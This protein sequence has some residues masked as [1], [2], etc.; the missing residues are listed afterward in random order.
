MKRKTF[1]IFFITCNICIAVL[2]IK[3]HTAIV[4]QLYQKQ[5]NEKTKEALIQKRDGVLRNLYTL[6]NPSS[7]KQF[8]T[9]QLNMHKVCL[10]QIKTVTSN[11]K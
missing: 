7:I 1:V 6:K 8:A 10:H 3:N 5:R 9:E 11:E 4:R 2:H